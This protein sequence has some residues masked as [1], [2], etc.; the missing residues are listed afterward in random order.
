MTSEFGAALVVTIGVTSLL[1][2]RAR[3]ALPPVEIASDATP[4]ARG[5]AALAPGR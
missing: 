3:Q 2:W 1:F 5:T 4:L